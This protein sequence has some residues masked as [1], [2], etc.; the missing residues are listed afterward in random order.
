[1]N[2]RRNLNNDRVVQNLTSLI[3]RIEKETKESVE[4]TELLNKDL[5]TIFSEIESYNKQLMELEQKERDLLKTTDNGR[6]DR[7][8]LQKANNAMKSAIHQKLVMREQ[9]KYA[10]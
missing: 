10:L 2:M 3:K 5:K 7:K 8:E 4:Y 9:E 6:H 1:M